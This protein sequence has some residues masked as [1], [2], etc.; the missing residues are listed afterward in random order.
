LAGLSKPAPRL[1]KAKNKLRR[2]VVLQPTSII[3]ELEDAVRSGPSEKRVSTL[4]QVTDLFLHGGERLS[5]EQIRIFDDAL[6]VLT[7]CV[8]TRARVELSKRI[9]S[10]DYAPP[11]VIRELARDDEIAVAEDVLVRSKRLTTD[12]L[13][14]IARTRGQDHLFAISGRADLP[15]VITDAI[16]DC[17][18]RRVVHKLADNTS[19]RFSP[20]GYA[21]MVARAEADDELTEI[22]WLRAD[23]PINF[24][25]DLLRRATD[26][27]RAR[28]TAIA[29]PGLQNE[30]SRVLKAIADAAGVKPEQTRDFTRAEAIVRRMKGLNELNDPAIIAFAD[31]RRFAEVTAAL[32]IKTNAP[33]ALIAKVMEG[34]RADLV[35]IPCRAAALAW[36]TV[37]AILIHREVKDRIDERTLEIAGKDYGK[38]SVETAQRTLRFWQLHDKIDSL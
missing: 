10:L 21:G 36:T 9:A 32:A 30:I 19:A 15:E 24:V 20:A 7:A 26:A 27:V 16:V 23:L 18:E 17:G 33:S 38:L 29:P 1:G 25:R 4:R 11:E 31:S 34:Y 6:C 2:N 12:T 28:L 3:A 35:L 22:L 37:K 14:E 13:V 8:E 5:E